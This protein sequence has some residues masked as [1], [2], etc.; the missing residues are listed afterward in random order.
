[1]RLRI[2]Y[3]K[4]RERIGIDEPIF[5]AVDLKAVDSFSHCIFDSE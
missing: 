4:T 1:M 2:E 5:S 3:L